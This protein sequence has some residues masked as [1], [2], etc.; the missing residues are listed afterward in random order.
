LAGD[1]P[2]RG[3]AALGSAEVDAPECARWTWLR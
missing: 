1:I 2:R 3:E